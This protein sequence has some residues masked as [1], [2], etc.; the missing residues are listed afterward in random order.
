MS[1]NVTGGMSTVLS[2]AES[3]Y[4]SCASKTGARLT[5]V[6][7][8]PR[9]CQ[10]ED[11]LSASEG[12]SSARK[13]Q[14]IC[15]GRVDTGVPVRPMRNCGA[16]HGLA[17]PAV[18]GG[19]VAITS[20]ARRRARS[21]RAGRARPPSAA[22]GPRPAG[23]SGCTGRA[24]MGGSEPGPYCASSTRGITGWRGG[25][26]GPTGFRSSGSRIAKSAP[27]SACT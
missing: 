20:A 13:I 27:S 16:D 23:R 19:R 1:V 26:R 21:R 6:S 10:V 22:R 12:Q 5:A 2:S 9:T 3:M 4:F 14:A 24:W 25:R 15:L 17:G 11:T 8:K 7:L 18:D